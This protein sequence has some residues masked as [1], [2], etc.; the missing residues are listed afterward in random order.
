MLTMVEFGKSFF[1]PSLLVE[2]V[3]ILN[4]I[5]SGNFVINCFRYTESLR[6]KIQ[7]TFSTLNVTHT[8]NWIQLSKQHLWLVHSIKSRSTPIPMCR[9][10]TAAPLQWRCH[11]LLYKNSFFFVFML[12]SFAAR[13]KVIFFWKTHFNSAG[14]FNDKRKHSDFQ[15]TKRERIT[16]KLMQ[17]RWKSFV[18]TFV[19]FF[20][21]FLP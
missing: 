19:F 5:H 4:R 17:F 10:H 13:R 6:L 9:S 16:I 7:R 11:F 18:N 14:P 8:K 2:K 3:A 21:I 12:L 15:I 20:A 1:F